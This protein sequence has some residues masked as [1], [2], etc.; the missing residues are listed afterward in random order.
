MLFMGDVGV[1]SAVGGRSSSGPRGAGALW[2]DMET[3]A[4]TKTAAETDRQAGAPVAW[5]TQQQRPQRI[6][7]AW[8]LH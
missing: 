5:Q 1:H 2:V 4:D 8:A 3:D 6:T 7:Q